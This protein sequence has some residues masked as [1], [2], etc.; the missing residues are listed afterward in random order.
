MKFTLSWLK[1]HLDTDAS[2]TEIT[3]KL[4]EIGLELEDFDE[5]EL[6]PFVVA[7]VVEAV[8]HPNADKLR[9]CT[10]DAG[11]GK[12]FN[13][14]CGAPNARTGMKGVFAPVGTYVPGTGVQLE[15]G[16][17]R[18]ERSEGMLCSER[19]LM[20][21]ED[22]DGIIDL[23]DDA[24][25]GMRYVDYKGIYDPVIE[26]NVTP[27]RG[28]ALGVRGVA[29]DLAAAGIGMLKPQRTQ[30]EG[31]QGPSPVSVSIETDNC[32]VFY[33]RVVRGVK[34][35]E[36]P[37]WVQRALEAVGE[38]P[39]SALVDMTNL[40]TLD[41]A[42]PMHVYDIAKLQGNIKVRLGQDGDA[43]ML[44]L[45]DKTYSFD[46][47]MTLVTDDRGPIGVGGVIGGESTGVDKNTN[48]VLIEAA[49]WSPTNIARTGRKLNVHT[50][51][52]FRFE[53]HTD[54]QNL[55]EHMGVATQLVLDWC[56]GEAGE[57]QVAGAAP[58]WTK[59]LDYNPSLC[60]KRGG[61]D[62]PADRQR[63]VLE[64]LGFGV[65]VKGD[66]LFHVSVP[67][68]R[69][70]IDG[71]ADL[72]EEVL[73]IVGYNSI[74]EL[75]FVRPTNMPQSVVSDEQRKRLNMH[76]ALAAHGLN[77]AVMFSFCNSR[78][79]KHFGWT[80]GQNADDRLRLANPIS[81]ELDV[82]RPSLLPNLLEACKRNAARGY[83][84][85][86]LFEVGL[87]FHDVTPEGQKKSV[88]GVRMGAI[89]AKTWMADEAKADVFTAKADLMAALEA[90]EAPAGNAQVTRN[91]P[92]WY[93]P[94]RSGALA[95]GKN[96][97]G[98]FG[99]LHPRVLKA[100][101]IKGRVVAFEAML[102]AVPEQRK[103]GATSTQKALLRPSAFQPVHKDYAFVV[104]EAV[105]ADKVLRA[106]KG[107][108]KKLIADVR[109]FDIYRGPGMD[110]G[111]KSLALAV[112]LQPVEA[113]LTD[114]QLDAVTQKIV[115]N[116]SKSAGGVLRG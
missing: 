30:F 90:Y 84:D 71:K 8:Q 37:A 116:V 109:L 53:R 70:D 38:R 67:S 13:V 31:G 7:H 69:P 87:R 57:L 86:A 94:G 61:L 73:R 79:A 10:V 25:V 92:D 103:K 4:T 15:L 48:D 68:F 114:E 51:A 75:D 23:P 110:E 41:Q 52:R 46:D 17:L 9:V 111:K 95:L 33:Y 108:D 43:E 105:E 39:I 96:V 29:R 40:M 81:D 98:Y 97:L 113:T 88:A 54:S 55:V 60:A 18:G 45:N 42:R 32:P 77:E 50:N 91:V 28:D 11:T 56:G 5:G 115:A 106:I 85:V 22:H 6:A 78:T 74:P 27:N 14:V 35:G 63:E 102:D 112:T 107:A 104:D 100:M 101:G 16:N 49:L 20:I 2:V 80:E 44:A 26:I 21:S 47:Q 59:A 1:Q 34:N 58:A 76:R 72:V 62:V 24:P 12:T 93:H 83:G 89:S 19:E 99:E 3:D 36:S 82:M 66:D 64:T 65:Q